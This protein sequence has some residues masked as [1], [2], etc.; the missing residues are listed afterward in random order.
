MTRNY[1][2]LW[3]HCSECGERLV[4]DYDGVLVHQN[5]DR[6]EDETNIPIV[7]TYDEGNL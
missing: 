1:N 7:F 6:C 3:P 2:P 5:K 4:F